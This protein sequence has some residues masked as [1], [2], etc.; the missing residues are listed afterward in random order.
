MSYATRVALTGVL[1]IIGGLATALSFSRGDTGWGIVMGLVTLSWMVRF[2]AL[3]NEPYRRIK[4]ERALLTASTP[5]QER[6]Q[7][8]QATD[9]V[10]LGQLANGMVPHEVTL[11]VTPADIYPIPVRGDL[12]VI[13]PGGVQEET[14]RVVESL[15]TPDLL[16]IGVERGLDPSRP[17]A[18]APGAVV[19]LCH[20]RAR[21]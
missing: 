16:M 6:R 5:E 12:I 18:H 15:R 4:A 1:I 19:L 2:W 9:G 11:N 17:M 10:L 7:V 3:S 13:E 14:C 21:V 20:E 8:F